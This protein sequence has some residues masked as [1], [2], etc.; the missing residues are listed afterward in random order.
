MQCRLYYVF[1]SKSLLNISK[2]CL[3]VFAPNTD[4][5]V[6][7]TLFQ[8]AELS[9][10]PGTGFWKFNSSLLENNRY[11][12]DI[13]KCNVSAEDKYKHIQDC[14]LKWDLIKMELRSFSIAYAKK[15]GVKAEIT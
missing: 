1:M 6:V 12:N 7:V 5:S 2:E 14:G 4:H 15:K 13:R 10:K 11:V 8:S 9:R 3:L